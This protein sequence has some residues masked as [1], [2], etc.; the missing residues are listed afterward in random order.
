MLNFKTQK[1]REVSYKKF[2]IKLKRQSTFKKIQIYSQDYS[3]YYFRNM[4][5]HI[6]DN[7]YLKIFYTLLLAFLINPIR[8][9]N[10]IYFRIVFKI[11][12]FFYNKS[13]YM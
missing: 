4:I 9:I 3:D 2:I 1:K 10:K 7:N 12:Y 11:S 6:I 8:I 13:T 5:I